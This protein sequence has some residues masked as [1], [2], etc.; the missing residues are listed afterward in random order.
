[1]EHDANLLAYYRRRI[2]QDHIRSTRSRLSGNAH[3]P[4]LAFQPH[5]STNEKVGILG[6]GIGGLYSALILD[7]L[8]IKYEILEASER[9]GGRLS[10]FRFKGGGEYDYFD[11]GAMRFPMPKKKVTGEYEDGLMKRFGELTQYKKLNQGP[12]PP[13][14]SKLIPFHFTTAD[15]SSPG[16]LYVNGRRLS[17]NDTNPD[18]GAHEFGVDPRYIAVGVSAI[19]R[20]VLQPFVDKLLEDQKNGTDAGWEMLE[21]HDD[22][23]MRAYMSFVY[24]PSVHLHLPATHLP[25][26]VIDWCELVDGGSTGRYNRALSEA[27]IGAMSFGKSGDANIEWKCFDGGSQTLTEYIEDYIRSTVSNEE[28]V[29]FGKRVTAVRSV[30]TIGGSQ[31]VYRHVVSTLP[32]PVLCTIDMSEAKITGPQR[33]AL[34]QLECGT[35]VKVG[36]L[37]ADAWWHTKLGITGGQSLTDLPIRKIVY[38][39]HGAQSGTPSRVLIASYPWN[40]DAE[41]LGALI[42][43]CEW[44]RDSSG[45][46]CCQSRV[47]LKEL[48]LRNLAEVHGGEIT[49]EFLLS[50]YKDMHAFN[51]SHNPYAMGGFASFS[52]GNFKTLYTSLTTPA[53]DGC[54]HFAGEA[55]S[56]HHAWTVGALHSAWRAVYEYLCTSGQLD[57]IERFKE[58]WGE[59]EEWTQSSESPD[60]SSHLD[61]KD[62]MMVDVAEG[63]AE[64]Y[65]EPAGIR[66]IEHD[67]LMQHLLSV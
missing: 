7:S 45:R 9:T 47:A 8:D 33:M 29:L 26:N 42:C 12:K 38:P 19:M 18:V 59:N 54:F 55:I 65:V 32:L 56:T 21:A 53:A 5:L 14:A 44:Q 6:A 60:T 31:H 46:E 20:D 62:W 28:L 36:V 25:T 24:V 61:D 39:S 1:M 2:L 35:A 67:L 11:V 40:Y 23:S 16:Y 3:R 41:R 57:K 10:T 34:R 51:W 15:G 48:I 66:S 22:Y 30:D 63:G 4:T 27:V 52:P 49:Y 50:Q 17:L 58:I 64:V 43:N 13:L 37:F